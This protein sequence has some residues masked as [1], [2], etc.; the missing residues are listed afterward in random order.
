MVALE[1]LELQSR[2]GGSMVRMLALSLAVLAFGCNRDKDDDN[3][4]DTGGSSNDGGF[5]G[6][7]DGGTG[8]GDA[9]APEVEALDAW[10]Y[11]HNTGDEAYFWIATVTA[12][13]PQ[14]ADT[15]ESFFEG[16][17][18]SS[19]GTEVA[20]YSLVCTQDGA[21]TASWNETEHGVLCSDATSYTISASVIDDEGN[22]SE[23]M[24]VT[25]KQ[26]GDS[27]GC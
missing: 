17:T 24:E 14:G 27:S 9:D 1:R 6:G 8:G 15:L 22:W 16:I 18:V 7:N 20:R 26:C 4:D 11:Q 10:C 19:A 3:D 5:G 2:H 23:P 25:G 13:D 21:C 12:D